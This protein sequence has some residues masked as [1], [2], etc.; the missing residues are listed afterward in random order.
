MSEPLVLRFAM[1][2]QKGIIRVGKRRWRPNVLFSFWHKISPTKCQWCSF[3]SFTPARFTYLSSLILLV[4]FYYYFRSLLH[5]PLLL[6]SL[7]LSH[8]TGP[9]ISSLPTLTQCLFSRHLSEALMAEMKMSISC[10]ISFPRSSTSYFFT[11][12]VTHRHSLSQM[13][14]VTNSS[15]VRSFRLHLRLWWLKLALFGL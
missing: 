13:T 2:A 8:L 5:P 10:L 9:L 11:S 1:Y 3:S 14:N 12:C 6:S 4:M 15:S 7:P